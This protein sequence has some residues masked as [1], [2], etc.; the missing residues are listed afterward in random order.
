MKFRLDRKN[1]A[2][3]FYLPKSDESTR[4]QIGLNTFTYLQ[5]PRWCAATISVENRDLFG[6]AKKLARAYEA[7]TRLRRKPARAIVVKNY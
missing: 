5:G 6:L 2:P 4:V 3:S 1:A 7:E